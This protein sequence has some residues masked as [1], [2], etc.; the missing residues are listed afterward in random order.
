MPC[1]NIVHHNFTKQ[2]HFAVKCVRKKNQQH[3]NLKLFQIRLILHLHQ[4]GCQ[5]V[6]YKLFLLVPNADCINKHW[7]HSVFLTISDYQLKPKKALCPMETTTT[8]T[9]NWPVQS[10]FYHFWPCI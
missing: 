4:E 6:K 2:G 10:W 9:F 3:I 7:K 1:K 8:P 5:K